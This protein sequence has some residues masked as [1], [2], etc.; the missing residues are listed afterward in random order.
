MPASI[1]VI[2]N[3][4]EHKHIRRHACDHASAH[5]WAREH[6][7]VR[8]PR[9]ARVRIHAPRTCTHLG[10]RL[11]LMV[12]DQV[13]R[14]LCCCSFQ[15]ARSSWPMVAPMSFTTLMLK[16]AARPQG[17]GK[18]VGQ[19]SPMQLVFWMP[20]IAFVPPGWSADCRDTTHRPRRRT[21]DP[22]QPPA[23]ANARTARG[24]AGGGRDDIEQA[25]RCE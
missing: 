14:L 8:T 2:R 15:Y 18:D 9:D 20:W 23:N 16:L 21:G 13:S 10:S 4:C 7:H 24:E 6:T 17:A 5:S 19:E 11:M 3:V 1:H 25:A 22:T 12:G